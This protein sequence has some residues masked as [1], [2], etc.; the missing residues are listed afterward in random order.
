MKTKLSF[1]IGSR[2]NRKEL[3]D[4]IN[5]IERAYDNDNG[6]DI[7]TLIVFQNIR[8]NSRDIKMK[9]PGL[10]SFH[11]IDEE[12]LSKA[13]NYAIGKSSGEMLVF[14]D[15]DAEIRS[16][17]LEILRKNY[18]ITATEVFCGRILEKGSGKSFISVFEDTEEK[19]LT[20]RDFRYFMGSSHALMKKALNRIGLYDE[21]FGAGAK[22]PAAEESDLFFRVK[23]RGIE[24]KYIPDLVFYHPIYDQTTPSK[25]FN[26][27]YAGGAMLTKQ[28]FSDK[29][30]AFV[31]LYLILGVLSKSLLRTL[32]SAL[33]PE[34]I[35]CRNSRF[36]YKFVFR[37][38]IR[39]I[40][41]FIKENFT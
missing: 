38:M 15:D 18:S 11:Y 16:D 34:T 39:G 25:V 17:F 12:G 40:Y 9:Y 33:F 41:D 26:Y 1:I 37:G 8:R 4:C 36:R 24:V 31:Y 21:R 22:Y 20:R 30:N 35:R 3:Q 14:L 23:Q 13:R 27:A 28:I 2:A 19:Y 6:F 7:E 29:K 10:T 5:S 32:Q